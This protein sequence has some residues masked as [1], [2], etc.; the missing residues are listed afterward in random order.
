MIDNGINEMLT[1]ARLDKIN[2]EYDE[3]EM[4]TDVDYAD[5]GYSYDD[6]IQFIYD[7]TEKFNEEIERYLREIDRKHGTHYAPTGMARLKAI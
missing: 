6:A 7:T 2:F 3:L 5:M 1:S 4:V